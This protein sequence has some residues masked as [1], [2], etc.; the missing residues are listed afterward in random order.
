MAR[1]MKTENRLYYIDNLRV[2]LTILV[3]AH[4]V[5]QAYGPTGGYWPVQEAARAAL[6]GP[7]FTVNRSFF[8]SLFFMISG[9]FMVA[10]YQHSGPSAF[11]RSRLM[12]LGVPFLVYAAVMI[13]LRIFMFGEHITRWN[14]LINTGHLWYIQHLLLFSMGYAAL[15][16]IRRNKPAAEKAGNKLPGTLA[17]LAFAAALAAASALVRLWSPID[18]WLNLLGFFR[19]AFA[20]VPRDLGFFIIGAV[21]FPRAWFSRFPA[22]SGYVWLG[23]GVA[24]AALR[25]S[26]S[27][28]LSAAVPVSATVMAIAYPLWEAVLCCG[29][30]IGLLVLFRET[31]NF[32]GRLG[33]VLASNQY[34]AYV[35][36]PLLIVPLQLAIL[37]LQSP[38]L[39]KFALV[40]A[41]GVPVV[42]L[43]SRLSR[44]PRFMKAV[45]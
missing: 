45:L 27:L 36:H 14:D 33:K 5:G 44:Q 29:M 1:M 9:Y 41:V 38:P 43:W 7:F 2:A 28:W 12:R 31:L 4:H 16:W 24:A 8:M 25:Y 19:V 23:V 32:Q 21:A 39:A 3:I 22:R 40:T 26:F 13:P 10:S 20:D 17:I 34:A 37:G 42:Y 11:I 15:R 35:W 30:C 18:N 6:L